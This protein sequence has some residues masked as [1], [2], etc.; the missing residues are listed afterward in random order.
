MYCYV[1]CTRA[2]SSFPAAWKEDSVK[3]LQSADI[4]RLYAA[5]NPVDHKDAWRDLRVLRYSESFSK[6]ST[7]VRLLTPFIQPPKS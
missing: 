4:G 5:Y 3:A 6:M 7:T 1:R 2:V